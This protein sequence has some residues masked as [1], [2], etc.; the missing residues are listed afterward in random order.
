MT[1]NKGAFGLKT[2][3]QALFS[4]FL[5]GQHFHICFRSGPDRKKTAFYDFPYLEGDNQGLSIHR[6]R[7]FPTQSVIYQIDLAHYWT[8]SNNILWSLY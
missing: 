8:F 3:V 2:L 4:V 1:Q 5:M 7:S 6:N